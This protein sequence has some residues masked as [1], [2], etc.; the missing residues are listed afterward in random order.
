MLAM[1]TA[2]R[3]AGHAAQIVANLLIVKL[4]AAM[5][6]AES[7]T[8]PIVYFDLGSPYAYLALARA[9]SVLGREPQLQ[10][11]LLGAIF[12]AR[13]FGSWSATPSRDGR[14]AEIEARAARYGLPPLR[15]PAAW[16]T[17]GLK[18][19]R[20]ATWAAQQGRVAAFARSVFEREFGDGADICDV[21]VL[22]KCA[23]AAGLDAERMLAA[24]ET[25]AVKDALRSATDAAWRAGVRGVPSVRIGESIFY[26][27]DQLELAAAALAGS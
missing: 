24:I 7:D 22:R 9:D 8:A 5:Q 18:A 11:V 26:G 15:W 13:G 23:D 16:P 1:L 19:M 20:C 6:P 4:F 12:A 27:D 10:P 25:A 2:S 17:D 3:T 21:S 14:V